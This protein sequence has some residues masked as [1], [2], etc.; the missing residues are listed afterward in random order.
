MTLTAK[1]IAD[2]RYYQRNRERI[3]EKKKQ[4]AAENKERISEYNRHRRRHN[5][6]F[7]R[8]CFICGGMIL[9]D[10]ESQIWQCQNPECE[11]EFQ[12]IL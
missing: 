9:Q 1:Q 10:K 5:K 7:S 6:S 4:Y 12:E 8:R 3:L 2:R 11:A